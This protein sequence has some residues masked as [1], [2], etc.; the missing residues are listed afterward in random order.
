MTNS[1]KSTEPTELD[2]LTGELID[3]YYG[4]NILFKE[5]KFLIDNFPIDEYITYIYKSSIRNLYFSCKRYA[6]ELRPVY[7]TN[8]GTMKELVFYKGAYQYYK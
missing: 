2:F 3:A 6:S 7:N 5:Y 4:H 8:D 1:S